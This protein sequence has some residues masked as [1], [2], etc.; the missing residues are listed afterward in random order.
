MTV[1]CHS[2]DGML[3]MLESSILLS[4]FDI[5]ILNLGIAYAPLR[6]MVFTDRFEGS[7]NLPIWEFDQTC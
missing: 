4:I 2:S 7:V 6:Q 3:Y 1:L 5:Q